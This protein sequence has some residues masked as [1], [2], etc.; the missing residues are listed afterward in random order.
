MAENAWRYGFVTSYPRGSFAQT[1]YDYEPWHYR[2][3]GRDLAAAIR[4]G[5]LTPREY[6]WRIQ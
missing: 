1:C 3:V 6:L 5:G 4:A 2:Y